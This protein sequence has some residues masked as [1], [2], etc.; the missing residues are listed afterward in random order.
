[1]SIPTAE[2]L[3]AIQ[4]VPGKGKGLVATQYIPMGTR[5][6]SEKPILRAPEDQPDG[7]ALRA[8][9]REQV[10]ALTPDQRQTFLSMHNIYTDDSVSKYLS[11]FR[12]NA[13][14]F[15]R[16]EVGIFLDA[17]RINHACDNN[18]QKCW[19]EN[20]KRHTVHALRNIEKGEEITI[21]YLGVTNN[22]E[23]RQEALR[24]KF[25][26]TC[27]CRLCSL[28]PDQSQESDR[29]LDE[30]LRLDCLIGYGFMEILSAPVQ[31][32]RLVDRQITLY[33]EQGA[34]DA[35]LPRAFLDAAQIAIANGD[36]ARA[37][38]F[39][40]KAMLGWAVL[41]GDD[42][43]NVLTNKALSKDPSKHGLY[44][45]S[46]KWKTAVNDTPSGLDPAEFDNW[47]WRREKPKQPGQPTDF[48]NQTTFPAFSDL[49]NGT[50][51]RPG[52]HWIFLAEI[53]D[54]LTLARLQMDVKDI[55]DT[56]VPLFFYTD[57]RGCE[58]APSKVKKGYTIAIVY[59]ER[60]RFMFSEPGIRLERSSDIKI[61]PTSLD[62]LLAL[63][64]KVQN[65]SAEA[66]GMRTCHGCG[67]QS[68]TLK[69][70]AKCSLFWY[71]D[72]ACQIKG[73]NEKDHKADC[74]ILRDADLKGLFSLDLD[75]FEGHIEFPLSTTMA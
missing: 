10:D 50:T 6:L 38:I 26:F 22:R 7:Q 57:G 49:P 15:G 21:Y 25:A 16:D 70:C 75:K 47:L 58:L 42:S 29:R 61:F 65:F 4:D 68:A 32:L 39:A 66:C 1:M 31:K 51:R 30:I 45:H 71:C 54:F 27:A 41:G 67:K 8:S 56:M 9:L 28:P 11:I 36:L 37:S 34:N 46:M 44:G 13:L 69:K 60:H 5:I 19:N 33:N 20:I 72:G 12:T 62:N 24:R 14:P 73:W 2:L 43:S 63:S 48:R 64:D 55:D 74:K 3:Y 18:A 17:C 53:V 52:R 35:G 40:E 59:A 23:A